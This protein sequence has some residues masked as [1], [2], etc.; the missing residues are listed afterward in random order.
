MDTAQLEQRVN[1]IAKSFD[2]GA[3]RRFRNVELKSGNDWFQIIVNCSG[4]RD[5]GGSFNP[6]LNEFA[7]LAFYDVTDWILQD[8]HILPDYDQTIGSV[9]L[10]SRYWF[11]F[12]KRD[13][14]DV[15]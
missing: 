4:A 5:T 11:Q 1:E 10:G 14:H 12:V 2:F 15:R 6:R 3:D 13:R 7:K 9:Y 8:K